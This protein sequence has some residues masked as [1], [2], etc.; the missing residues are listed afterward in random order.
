MIL[1]GQLALHG[2]EH[3]LDP[4]ADSAMNHVPPTRFGLTTIELV[5]SALAWAGASIGLFS[6]VVGCKVAETPDDH[7]LVKAAR[8]AGPTT[9][10]RAFFNR[11]AVRP[12]PVPFFGE[13]CNIN[14]VLV[15]ER[16]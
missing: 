1:E 11:R 4:L 8:F 5:V 9:G 6:P 3:G 7:S 16:T 14:L 2:V 15:K 10:G 13:L 12:N